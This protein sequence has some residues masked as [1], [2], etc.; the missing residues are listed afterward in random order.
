MKKSK[1]LV[2]LALGG[3]VMISCSGSK[4]PAT[5]S[6]SVV[7]V[8]DSSEM[9]VEDK[10]EWSEE[11]EKELKERINYIY[12]QVAES[13]ADITS[14]GF[15]NTAF[16]SSRLKSLWNKLPDDD[17]VVDFDPYIN[18]QDYNKISVADIEVR[19]LQEKRAEAK[20]TVDLGFSEPSN[21]VL[22]M[23]KERDENNGQNWMIDDFVYEAPKKG[24]VTRY[25]SSFMARYV[26]AE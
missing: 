5:E 11:Q 15:E 10:K 25:F 17:L 8:K 7:A 24:G 3:I 18:A 4:K 9:V 22:R 16:F 21:I 1:F 20:V 13:Y 12:Q 23:V 14:S 6:D 26:S 19:K 2:A